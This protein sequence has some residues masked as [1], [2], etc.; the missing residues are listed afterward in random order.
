MEVAALGVSMPRA[1][2]VRIRSTESAGSTRV[3]AG[4]AGAAGVIAR[5]AGAA[6]PTGATGVIAGSAR[7]TRAAGAAGATRTAW[8]TWVTGAA[9]TPRAAGMI[10]RTTGTARAAGAARIVGTGGR[11]ATARRRR[12]AV[13]TRRLW[14]SGSSVGKPGA[15][16]QCRGAERSGDGHPSDKLLQLH[17]ASPIH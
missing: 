2:G 1:T 6:R 9:R 11:V 10:T 14:R 5:A 7:A 4:A 16:S 3:I 8:A 15:H 13:I 12:P 17:D